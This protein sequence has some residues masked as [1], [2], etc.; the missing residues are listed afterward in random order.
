MQAALALAL[1]DVAHRFKQFTVFALVF[2]GLD[3]ADETAQE[4]L[5]FAA[6]TSSAS[7]HPTNQT[8][9]SPLSLKSW[10][11][12]LLGCTMAD[13]LLAAHEQ[14]SHRRQAR[15]R[16]QSLFSLDGLAAFA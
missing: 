9:V 12:D 16:D 6:S 13:A 1:D 2:V 4:F 7:P 14:H 8:N 11:H 5:P 3:G 10:C 15:A